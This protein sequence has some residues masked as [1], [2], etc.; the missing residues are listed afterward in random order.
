MH[1]NSAQNIVSSPFGDVVTPNIDLYSFITASFEQHLNREALVSRT[2][3]MS[4]GYFVI[5]FPP[6][7]THSSMTTA[8]DLL[9]LLQPHIV[10]YSH[11]S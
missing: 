8:L 10:L 5:S 11:D 6:E 4:H 2:F 7:F 9:R 3:E 1:V